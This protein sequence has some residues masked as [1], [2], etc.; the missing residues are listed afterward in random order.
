MSETTPPGSPP[1]VI[2]RRVLAVNEIPREMDVPIAPGQIGYLPRKRAEAEIGKG[3][4]RDPDA[5]APTS[6]AKAP[7]AAE[8]RPEKPAAPT[9]KA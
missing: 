8:A 9:T 2:L 4:A 6:G 7:G 3:N 1:V 5:P